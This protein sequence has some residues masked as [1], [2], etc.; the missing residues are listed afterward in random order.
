MIALLVL[1]SVMASGASK[2]AKAA[3]RIDGCHAPAADVF[4][5]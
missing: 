2:N 1:A 3:V 5:S 4:L